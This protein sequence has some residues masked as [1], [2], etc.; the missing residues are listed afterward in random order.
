[1]I[2]NKKETTKKVKTRKYTFKYALNKFINENENILTP[3]PQEHINTVNTIF[4]QL[5]YHLPEK[6]SYQFAIYKI[7]GKIIPKGP[8]HVWVQMAYLFTPCSRRWK[9]EWEWNYSL[10]NQGIVF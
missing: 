4:E 1:M 7:L 5:E 6:I 8:Q 3:L 10:R 9:Y 2:S